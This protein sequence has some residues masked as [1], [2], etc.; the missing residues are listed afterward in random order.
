M[1]SRHDL[2][3]CA[4]CIV[5]LTIFTTVD[6][7]QILQSY[8][9]LLKATTLD[10]SILVMCTNHSVTA[11]HKAYRDSGRVGHKFQF[12]EHPDVVGELE[13]GVKKLLGLSGHVNW[14]PSNGEDIDCL[15]LLLHLVCRSVVQYLTIN[16]QSHKHMWSMMVQYLTINTHYHTS[17]S[18]EC[19]GVN[20]E[21]LQLHA[22][23]KKPY[24]LLQVTRESVSVLQVT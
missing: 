15:Q 2:C 3:L 16:T 17:N 21:A 10:Y 19:M 6:Q 18:C 12:G 7:F 9:L 5:R 13:R 24:F 1:L 22:V 14:S 4:G 23:Y 20:G 8:T 11:V